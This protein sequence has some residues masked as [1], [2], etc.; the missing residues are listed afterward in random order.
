MLFLIILAVTVTGPIKS[1]N[2]N[3]IIYFRYGT[4]LTNPKNVFKVVM[5]HDHFF[6]FSKNT[7]EK[8]SYRTGMY[9]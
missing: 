5:N 7:F 9:F 8:K 4:T 6:L 3:S 1:G 2:N